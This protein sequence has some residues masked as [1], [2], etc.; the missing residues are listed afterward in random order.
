MSRQVFVRC[1]LSSG[2]Q[3]VDEET[4]ARLFEP[5]FSTKTQGSGLGLALVKKVAED[6]AGSASLERVG[7]V[8]RAILRLPL[9]RD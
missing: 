6:L 5:F 3:R 4:R 9:S 1:R 2:I 8:T 7:A